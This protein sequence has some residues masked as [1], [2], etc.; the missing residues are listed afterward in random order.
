MVAAPRC[1]CPRSPSIAAVEH[2][3]TPWDPPTPGFWCPRIPIVTQDARLEVVMG[4]NEHGRLIASANNV[5]ILA[6]ET[7]LPP[8]PY[9]AD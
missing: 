3:Y 9:L 6:P 2:H 5:A 7:P 1:A 4:D 8:W